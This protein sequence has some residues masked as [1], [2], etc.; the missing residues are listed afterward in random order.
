MCDMIRLSELVGLFA[1]LAITLSTLVAT[2]GLVTQPASDS[3]PA[4]LVGV[5]D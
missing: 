2:Q 4:A 5:T 3:G 1:A